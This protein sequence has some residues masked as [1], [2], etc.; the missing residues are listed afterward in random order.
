M[1]PHHP[2]NV[3]NQHQ[4]AASFPDGV[5]LQPQQQ[6]ILGA[7][8]G[9]ASI[10]GGATGALTDLLGLEGELT[11]IQEGIRQIDQI[12]SNPA[13]MVVLQNQQH[14]QMGYNTS[15]MIPIG[16]LQPSSSSFPANHP[17]HQS[18]QMNQMNL[19]QPAPAA[20]Q[21]G[22]K[23]HYPQAIMSSGGVTS[24]Q[25]LFGATPFLPPPPSKVSG[26]LYY[27]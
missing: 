24:K 15:D 18:N 21:H 3:S 12:G 16:S 1:P 27:S 2:S 11:N 17:P 20:T 4:S 10:G 14:Q 9:P 25:D 22:H 8:G 26:L 5:S 13:A 19:T 23:P 7:V 6:R